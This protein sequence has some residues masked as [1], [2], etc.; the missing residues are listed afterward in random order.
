MPQVFQIPFQG[1]QGESMSI[2]REY[3]RWTGFALW[4]GGMSFV[5]TGRSPVAMAAEPSRGKLTW[6]DEFNG[7]AGSLPDPSK[8]SIETGGGGWGNR[9][10]ESY[11]NRRENVQQRDGNLVIT[12]CKESFTG[13]DKV[14][15]DYTSGRLQTKT[16]FAQTYGRFEARMQ[17]PS[18]KGIWPA[19]WLLGD[20][21][22]T[23]H[24]PACGEIDILETIGDPHTLYSTLHGPGYSGK[25]GI[26]AKFPLP[27]GQAVDDGFHVY[28]VEWAPERIRFFF[29]DHLIVERTPKDLPVGSRWVYDHPFFILLD[30]AVGGNWPGNPNEQTSFPQQLLVDYVRVY[31]GSGH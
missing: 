24:W 5:V 25:N 14:Q 1:L 27:P 3:L 31:D 6:S 9:E 29:D 17:L 11:T 16:H 21:A 8:W 19:F 12:A 7:E 2:R 22:E 26:S 28:A 10:L 13:S 18:G 23:A 15:R 4:V 30:L 20:N